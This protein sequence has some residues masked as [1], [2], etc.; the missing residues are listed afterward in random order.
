MVPFALQAQIRRM[1]GATQVDP[2]GNPNATPAWKKLGCKAAIAVLQAQ[3]KT[4]EL[5][6]EFWRLGLLEKR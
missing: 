2:R 3:G 4:A 6:D 1:I 5:K